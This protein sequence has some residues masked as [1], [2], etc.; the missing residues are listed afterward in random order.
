MFTGLIPVSETHEER[1][2]RLL[3]H[4]YDDR[5]EQRQVDRSMENT[6]LV[7]SLHSTENY[8]DAF[9]SLIDNQ[10]AKDYL[11]TDILAAP[12]DYPGQLNTRRA[13]AC[14][15]NNGE[16]SGIPKQVLHIVPMIGPLHV[17][18]NS[19]ETVFLANYNF[20]DKLF[21]QVYGPSKVLAKKPKPYRINLLLEL[22]FQGWTRVRLT[23][24]EKFAQIKDPE[25][26]YLIDLLDNTI[27]LVLDFYPII[28]R[29]GSW[30]AYQDAMFC[31]WA[32]F[33]RYKRKNY[34]KLPLSFL[35]D[36]FYW[37]DILFKIFKMNRL[38]F[39][40]STSSLNY[41]FGLSLTIRCKT[42]VSR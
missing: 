26:R 12:M 6:K 5:I 33:Y 20:F 1:V 37:T 24:L 2:E 8:I 25:V 16:T 15:M 10:S 31:V 32:V 4:S 7:G 35:S 22:A 36:A 18:L 17:S 42:H 28:F 34:N 39:S 40:M 21:H 3:V 9:K 30:P 23:V 27:S 13:V 14:C 11:E 29:S 38:I 41:C 19:C